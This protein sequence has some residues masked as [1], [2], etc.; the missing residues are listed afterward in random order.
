[1]ETDPAELTAFRAVFGDETVDYMQALNDHYGPNSSKVW[2]DDYVSFYAT[3][4]PWEDFAETFAH[5]LHMVDMLAALGG[6]GMEMAPFPGPESHP[7]AR[8]DFDPYTAP[9]EKLTAEIVPYSFAL[10]TGEPEH[11]AAGPLSVPPV[12]RDS[13]KDRLCESAGG[14]GGG[15]RLK[16]TQIPFGSCRPSVALTRSAPHRPRHRSSARRAR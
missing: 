7:G 1:M 15:A 10:N 4:H 12:A 2:T 3:S 6:F 9:T 11:G 14:E 16:H 8:V 5:Y 13:G